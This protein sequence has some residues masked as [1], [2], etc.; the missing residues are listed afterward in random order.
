M[1]VRWCITED[2]KT[3][4]T[5]DE[6]HEAKDGNAANL[7]LK[8]R[9]KTLFQGRFNMGLCWCH[10]NEVGTVVDFGSHMY[11]GLIAKEKP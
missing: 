10:M 11:F 4:A 5:G 9:V 3:P 6:W 8:E 1:S 7:A 2:W